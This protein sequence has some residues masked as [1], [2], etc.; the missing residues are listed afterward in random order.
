[1]EDQERGYTE[2]EIKRAIKKYILDELIY[3][4]PEITLESNLNLIDAE[5]VD[6]LGIF[7]LIAFIE[8]SFQVKI[9]PDE[10][11]LENFE[12]IDAIKSLVIN[13]LRSL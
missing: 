9:E 11:V 4:K 12:T 5:I 6:S 10:V 13:K 2:K 8:N 1:M 3:D 7:L